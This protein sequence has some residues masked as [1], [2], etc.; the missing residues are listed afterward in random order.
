MRAWCVGFAI[1]SAYSLHGTWYVL[2]YKVAIGCISAYAVSAACL[3]ICNCLFLNRT[4]QALIRKIK[5]LND[6]LVVDKRRKV[7]LIPVTTICH[8][9][10]SICVEL[11]NH[12]QYW[13]RLIMVIT[14][15]VLPMVVSGTF[16]IMEMKSKLLNGLGIVDVGVLSVGT[17]LFYLTL[18]KVESK[19]R[20][21]YPL[22]CQLLRHRPI[23][24]T[25]KLKLLRLVKQFDN[26]ISFTSW[27]TNKIDY[28]DYY[29]V[30]IIIELKF[31]T[32]S[33]QFVFGL[34]TNFIL[35]MTLSM[36]N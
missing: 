23:N 26:Q 35:I 12:N 18:A 36:D 32:I 6:L 3:M 4:C 21:C 34:I 14:S 22:M 20:K 16:V 8:Q 28:M 33:S 9:F 13:K 7:K 11:N 17:S 24:W 31:I 30:S 19:L 10:Q 15:T 2:I 5:V 1:F 25:L 27:D 29:D